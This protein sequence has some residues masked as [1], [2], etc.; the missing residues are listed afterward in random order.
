MSKIPWVECYRP[1]NFEEIVLDNDNKIILKNIL[2]STIFPNLLLYGP[3]GT[4]KTTTILNLIQ[5]YQELTKTK[6]KDL[7]IHLNASDERGIDVIR[8]QISVFV[9]SKPLFN[10]GIKFVILDEVDYLTK[11]AQQALKH[12]LQKNY[13]NTRFCLMCN[14]ISKIEQGLQ[15]EFVKLRFNKLPEEE[16]ISFLKKV[17]INEGLNLSDD[18]LKSIQQ[19]FLSDIRSMINYMQSNQNIIQNSVKEL[20]IITCEIWEDLIIK[21]KEQ[22]NQ[23]INDYIYKMTKTF[24]NDKKNIIKDLLNYIIRNKK[25]YVTFEFLSFCENLIHANNYNN[26]NVYVDYALTKLN[27]F[28][29]N[30]S[31]DLV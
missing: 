6:S 21:I 31:H 27:Y 26:N 13:K 1:T 5:S 4:G 11:N 15:N 24:N 12:L 3:P 16:V 20:K 22:S 29:T 7:I 10:N 23:S 17:S 18:T 14:Y 2:D 19:K 30:A 25:E 28:L 8:N 9:N